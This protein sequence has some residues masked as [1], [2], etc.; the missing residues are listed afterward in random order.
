MR[1]ALLPVIAIGLLT[2]WVMPSGV[3]AQEEQDGERLN[4]RGVTLASAGYRRGGG[5]YGSDF[6][7]EQLDALA[8][9]GCNWIAVTEH[10]YMESV[11]SPELRWR[12][13]GGER[14]AQTVADARER[15]IKVLFKPHVWSRDF[16]GGGDWHGT[17]EMQSEADWQAFFKNY[18]DY[19]VAHAKI[20]QDAGADALCIGTELKSTT[21]REA[22]WR[23]L[24]RRVREVYDGALT[25]SSCSDSFE[26]IR[27]WDAVDCVGITAYYR[28]AN[29]DNPSENEVRQGWNEVYR[30]LIPFAQRVGRPICFTELGYSVSPHAAQAPWEYDVKGHAPE[31]QAMLYRV[32]LD[33]AKKSGVVE[34]VLLWKWFTLPD[35]LA[36]QME[37]HDAFGIQWRP[38]AVEAIR[39]EFG[40]DEQVAR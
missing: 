18:G 2:L 35:D 5:G 26:E 9:L 38:L 39:G 21:H 13:G 3:D 30:R 36:E 19:M 29:V 33:E 10:V 14:L 32:A 40:G 28:V 22:E 23:E 17:V 25:Y 12:E 6:A 31:L 15:G 37:R 11:R 27:W 4:I 16:H 8:A 20:A 34:G 1:I 7:R 24:I